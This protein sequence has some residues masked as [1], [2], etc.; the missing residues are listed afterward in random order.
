MRH[1]H[2]RNVRCQ[3]SLKDRHHGRDVTSH[4]KP[5]GPLMCEGRRRLAVGE[6]DVGEL[7]VGELAVG[8]LEVWEQ[9]SNISAAKS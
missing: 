2:P 9:A 1:P 4:S 8:E 3:L 5:R 7:A 6:L